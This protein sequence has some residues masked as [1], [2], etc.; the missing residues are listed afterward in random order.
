MSCTRSP[1][2]GP[3]YESTNFNLTCTA[4]VPSVVDTGISAT[5]VW[6]DPKGNTIPTDDPRRRLMTDRLQSTLVFL[7][8][9][10]GDMNPGFN[11]IGTY[12]CRVTVSS[13]DR[14]I[15][16]GTNAASTDIRVDSK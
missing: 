4:T 6:T 15:L 9:D 8:V 5:V 14:L 7:P 12:N 2:T 3:I 16:S 11:D 10:N 13:T 1:A